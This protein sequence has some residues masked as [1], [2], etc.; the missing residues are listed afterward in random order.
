[1]PAM[2][3]RRRIEIDGILNLHFLRLVFMIRIDRST[4]EVSSRIDSRNI[5]SKTEDMEANDL[6][7]NQSFKCKNYT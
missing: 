4:T 3:N 7:F 6:T 2:P 5:V 1:M